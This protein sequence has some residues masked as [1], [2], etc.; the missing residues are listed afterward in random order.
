MTAN[1]ILKKYEEEHE[2]HLYECDRMWIIEA[3]EEYANQFK[4]NLKD[5]Q[6][7]KST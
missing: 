2:Y 3:M 5:N 7:A 6:D 4:N 1:E